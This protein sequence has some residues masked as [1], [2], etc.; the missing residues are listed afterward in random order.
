[1]DVAAAAHTSCL[2]E[3]PGVLDALRRRHSGRASGPANFG[4]HALVAC[5]KG[6]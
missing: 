6:Q 4:R 5:F 1:L 2:L 3:Q